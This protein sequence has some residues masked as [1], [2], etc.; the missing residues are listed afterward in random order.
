VRHLP[1]LP[2]EVLSLLAPVGGEVWVDCT[3]GAGGH[4]ALIA[5]KIAPNGRLIGL[6]RDAAMLDLAR[7]QLANPP[8]TLVQASFDQLSDVL[9][10]LRIEAVDGVLADLGFCSNQMDDPARG[11]SF[12]TDGPLDMR[13]DPDSGPTAAELLARLDERELADLIFENGEERFSR[14][15]AKKIVAARRTQPIA[16]TGQLAELVRSCVPRSRGIDPATRT[17]QALRIVVNDEL[18]ALDALLVQLP[19]LVRRGGR[20]GVISFHSLE[21]RR[22][23]QALRDAD[24]WEVKTK[25]PV[26]PGDEEQR[27]NPR[28]RSAKLRVA[29]RK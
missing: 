28:S 27:N 17:F 14:R 7:P 26:Q 20:V 8:V 1:V 22:V 29:V 4:A 12:Q 11:L 10:N 9:A 23:K 2:V 13:M 21:D 15:I 19:K 18:A 16:T 24:V 25:K 6:D 3:V 5:Q